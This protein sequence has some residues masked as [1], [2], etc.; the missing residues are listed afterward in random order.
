MRVFSGAGL[1]AV[2]AWP[3]LLLSTPANAQWW[4]QDDW[5]SESRAKREQGLVAYE[6]EIS[7]DGSVE[8]CTITESSGF[9]RLDEVTCAKILERARF[10]PAR[11]DAGR[12]IAS[13]YKGRVRW[14]LDNKRR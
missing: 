7:K 2:A 4:N 5:P 1:T 12:P 3:L 10:K 6:I 8:G 9:P 11:D 13:T 14:S